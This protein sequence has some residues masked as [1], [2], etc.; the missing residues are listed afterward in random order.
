VYTDG[1]SEAFSEAGE[2]FGEER[3]V[4]TVQDARGQSAQFICG[5][6]IKTVRQ[7]ASDAVES[8]DMTLIVVKV[9]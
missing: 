7:F 2:E 1:L 8:D 3:L 6:L 9:K 4:R 5:H